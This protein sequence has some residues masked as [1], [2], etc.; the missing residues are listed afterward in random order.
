MSIA[1][2]GGLALQDARNALR[3]GDLP[4]A[5]HAARAVADRDPGQL[6]AWYI[7]GTAATALQDYDTAAKAFGEGASRA[8]GNTPLRAQMLVQRTRPLMAIGRPDLAVE[9]IRAALVIGISDANGLALAS[10]TFIHAHL[11]EEGQGPAEGAVKLDP[12][13]AYAWFNLG[14]IRQFLGNTSGA[15]QAFE[16]ATSASNNTMLG[17]YY[18]LS[19]LHRW[20]END[21]HIARLESLQ[22]RNAHEACSVAYALFKEYDD[23]DNIEAAWDALQHG[24]RL[25]RSAQSWTRENEVA[26]TE[27][28]KIHLPQERFAVRDERPRSGPR[29]I[30]ITGLPRSGTTLVERILAAHSQVQPLGELKT[31]GVVVK[32]LSGATGT[33]LLTPQVIAAAAHLDPLEIAKAY[34]RETAYLHNGRSVTI[35]KLPHNHEYIG[36]IRLAFPDA[37]IITLDRHPM[38]ALFSAYKMMFMGM[39]GWS[40]T[41]EDLADHYDQ[42]CRLMTHWK[43]MADEDMV[44]V[45]LER[46]IAAPE[47]EIRRLVAA[48]RLPFEAACLSPHEVV[49]PITTASAM[50]VRKPINAEGIGGWR[51]Y[52]NQLRPL[53]DRLTEM[54]YL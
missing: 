30:F 48:C 38:D 24:S 51:R 5:V 52:E 34:T 17:A 22:C 39:H 33:D 20:T 41:Q 40:Y 14:C 35:D 32:R 45:S 3:T 27:A 11:P 9:S 15:Q 28:W 37:V 19:R 44:D 13:H 8:P 31:F 21:N 50:Q 18:N 1:T 49:G 12:H 54:G 4:A 47:T 25:A 26:L 16:A 6:E 46:L 36:L 10:A 42:F 23:V 7:L 53:H 2:H 43:T 29:R